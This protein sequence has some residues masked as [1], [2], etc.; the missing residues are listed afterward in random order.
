MPECMQCGRWEPPSAGLVVCSSCGGALG[1][2]A[3]Q[4]PMTADGIRRRWLKP[5]SDEEIAERYEE[6]ARIETLPLSQR[7]IGQRRSQTSDIFALIF[8]AWPIG[9]LAGIAVFGVCLLLGLPAGVALVATPVGLIG[10]WLL[11]WVLDESA[12][13]VI[14]RLAYHSD[15]VDRHARDVLGLVSTISLL[16]PAAVTILV[17]LGLLW[18]VA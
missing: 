2:A 4:A 6:W 15:W 8:V 11:S 18:L 16:I 7:P 1:P 5:P 9:V 14:D 12:W 3:R 10:G 13:T 17:S